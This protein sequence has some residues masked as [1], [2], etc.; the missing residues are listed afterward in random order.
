MSNVRHRNDLRTPFRVAGAFLLVA[1]Y[2][3]CAAQAADSITLRTENLYGVDVHIQ[4]PVAV[5]PDAAALNLIIQRWIG[6]SCNESPVIRNTYMERMTYHGPKDCL[7]A[8]SRA[9]AALQA[10]AGR[11]ALAMG[12]CQAEI[13]AKAELNTAGMLVISLYNFGLAARGFLGTSNESEHTEYLNLHIATG[14]ILGL[15]DLLKP[16]YSAVL[17]RMIVRSLRAQS[18]VAGSETLTQ[19]GFLTNAPPIP[20]AMEIRREGL[21]FSYRAGEITGKSVAPPNVVVSY[22]ELA[23]LIPADSPLHLL[24]DI[25]PDPH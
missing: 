20:A 3:W 14:R 13:T 25:P 19:A 16:S 2:G 7:T 12:R 10:G 23:S 1:V 5:G 8:L 24:L 17:Q 9:C 21:K 22:K 15:G 18:H 6:G 4:Y 11:T